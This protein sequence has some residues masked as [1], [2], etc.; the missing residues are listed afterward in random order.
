[1]SKGLR[2]FKLQ[3]AVKLSANLRWR[4]TSIAPA[5]LDGEYPP[6]S[7]FKAECSMSYNVYLYNIPKVSNPAPDSQVKEFD[8]V[9]DAKISGNCS[10]DF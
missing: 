2:V 7:H 1:M 3:S 8:S 4:F 6:K 10:Q 5:K 9:Y